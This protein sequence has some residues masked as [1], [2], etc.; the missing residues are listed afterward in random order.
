MCKCCVRLPVVLSLVVCRGLSIGYRS[1][2]RK[3]T[4][5]RTHS[6]WLG[7]VWTNDP[8]EMGRTN[9]HVLYNTRC[10]HGTRVFK[11]VEIL[12]LYL[13]LIHYC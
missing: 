3:E 4:R 9:L 10:M 13:V 7:T 12:D 5:E 2:N 11:R 8:H 1:T 6:C